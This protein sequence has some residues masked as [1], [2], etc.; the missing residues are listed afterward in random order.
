MARGITIRELSTELEG[1]L[2][3]QGLLCLDDSM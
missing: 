1:G 2:D 3:V